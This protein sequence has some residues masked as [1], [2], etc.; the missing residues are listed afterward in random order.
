MSSLVSLRDTWIGKLVWY[1]ARNDMGLPISNKAICGIVI[2]V[3]T[4]QTER[5]VYVILSGSDRYEAWEGDIE[6]VEDWDEEL[7]R[8]NGSEEKT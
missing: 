1:F 3:Y 7:E 8:E 4:S 6:L 2:D 5:E